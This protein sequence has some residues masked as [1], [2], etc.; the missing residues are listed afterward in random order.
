MFLWSIFKYICNS[1]KYES[2]FIAIEV[3]TFSL[4]SAS[5]LLNP[6]LLNKYTHT[7]TRNVFPQNIIQG[8]CHRNNNTFVF[9]H[10]KLP[11]SEWRHMIFLLLQSDAVC[12]YKYFLSYQLVKVNINMKSLQYV[13]CFH[14]NKG[15]KYLLWCPRDLMR[16]LLQT[17]GRL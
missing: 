9:F 17:L 4:H 7:H 1:D 2:C 14:R 15:L 12:Q 13:A 11:P 5:E 16:K 6:M 10:T 3:L 8:W